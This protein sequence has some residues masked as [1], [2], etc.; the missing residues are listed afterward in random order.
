MRVLA[1]INQI[2]EKLEDMAE[3]SPCLPGMMGDPTFSNQIENIILKHSRLS[4]TVTP[5]FEGSTGEF[6]HF[7]VQIF[8]KSEVDLKLAEISIKNAIEDFFRRN[9][10]HLVSIV[11]ISDPIHHGGYNLHAYFG[12]TRIQNKKL[13][14]WF[15]VLQ[16]N[17]YDR[18][19][20]EFRGLKDT[21]LQKE[22]NQF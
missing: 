18:A 11:V 3:G 13:A 5:H 19:I 16:K 8:P 9:M 10:G 6:L 17:D 1:M 20:R 21:A 22:L 7:I 15:T 4:P 14:K 2:G 12:H